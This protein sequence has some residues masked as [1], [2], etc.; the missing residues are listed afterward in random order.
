MG[1]STSFGQQMELTTH[2]FKPPLWRRLFT[3]RVLCVAL[4]LLLIG[5]AFWALVWPRGPIP[6]SREV[7]FLVEP[8]GPDGYIDYFAALLPDDKLTAEENAAGFYIRAA[9]L[10]LFAICPAEDVPQL[11]I[12]LG[13][14]EI[15]PTER[16][17]RISEFGPELWQSFD[18]KDLSEDDQDRWS[19]WLDERY[20][21]CVAAPWASDQYPVIK[22]WLDANERPLQIISEGASKPGFQ[23]RP[24]HDGPI[25]S[26]Q[27]PLP[28]KMRYLS[29]AIT[30]R[31]MN[32][33]AVGDLSAAAADID[34]ANR[35][36]R[37][38]NEKP[39][40]VEIL[41]GLAIEATAFR[42]E[43][44]LIAKLNSPADV[45]Q[46]RAIIQQRKPIAGLPDSINFGERLLSLDMIQEVDREARGLL[47]AGSCFIPGPPLPTY[48]RSYQVRMIDTVE[49]SQRVNQIYDEV[50]AALEMPTSQ[51]VAAFAAVKQRIRQLA[52]ADA[53]SVMT[54]LSGSTLNDGLVAEFLS[55]SSYVDEAYRR[56]TTR[57]KLLDIACAARLF[58]LADGRPPSKRG[59]LVPRYLSEWPRDDIRGEPFE[60]ATIDGRWRIFFRISGESNSPPEKISYQ[61][62]IDIPYTIEVWDVE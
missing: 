15:D 16:L 8:V 21:R 33:I 58:E 7:T 40:T 50:A 24:R 19:T 59:D 54:F 55:P 11:S 35:V 57:H 6:I 20:E 43:Q 61:S 62:R 45:A 3:L 27:L 36:A 32:R 49:C 1:L 41:V 2:A 52:P 37:H 30:I 53:N 47:P 29:R 26:Y 25:V 17:T 4:V 48:L 39:F 31:A 23:F 13:V 60:D 44:A 42:A 9:G 22:D 14:P 56:H 12:D 46:R 51:R 34:T 28:Q 5:S 18:S 38:L 10:K